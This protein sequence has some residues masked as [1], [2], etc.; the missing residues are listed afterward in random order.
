VRGTDGNDTLGS[1]SFDATEVVTILGGDGDDDITY[2]TLT[3]EGVR[4][5]QGF[6]SIEGGDGDDRIELVQN[7]NV[8]SEVSGGEGNDVILGNAFARIDG[9]EGD[10]LIMLDRDGL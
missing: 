6:A 8:S 3:E 7:S 10:D 5:P 2:N 4:E 1:D 9:D